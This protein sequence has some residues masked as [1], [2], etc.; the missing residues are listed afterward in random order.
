[1]A[2]ISPPANLAAMVTKQLRESPCPKSP[3][4]KHKW[5]KRGTYWPSLWEQCEYCNRGDYLTP[6]P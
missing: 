1:M 4:K 2:S 3:D 5:I 6:Q